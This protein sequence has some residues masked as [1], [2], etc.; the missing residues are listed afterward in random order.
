[1]VCEG[2]D[3]DIIA[4]LQPVHDSVKEASGRNY[5]KPVPCRASL[6]LLEEL[7]RVLTARLSS[8]EHDLGT[9]KVD[10]SVYH[11]W[12]VREKR[13]QK[14]ASISERRA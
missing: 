12:D 4:E 1:M 11:P 2:R 10:S 3:N 7:L 9:R 5:L 13:A 6:P 8:Y 14:E